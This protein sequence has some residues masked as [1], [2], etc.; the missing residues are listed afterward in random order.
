MRTINT[1]HS[2]V[3]AKIYLV[4]DPVIRIYRITAIIMLLVLSFEKQIPDSEWMFLVS[5]YSP[6]QR[7]STPVE[8]V[9]HDSR[10]HCVHACNGGEGCAD[11]G[12][13]KALSVSSS[14]C[15]TGFIHTHLHCIQIYET[16]F[17]VRHSDCNYEWE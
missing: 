4:R 7:R 1:T 6:D 11:H 17:P 10:Q 2:V 3:E 15:S 13:H 5:D 16:S 14:F 9:A 8:V 12:L